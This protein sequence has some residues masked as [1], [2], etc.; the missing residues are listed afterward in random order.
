MAR[1]I[2]NRK[3][4]NKQKTSLRDNPDVQA[5]TLL[6]VGTA[7]WKILSVTS[8]IDF[9]LSIK[10]RYF[11]MTY[12]FLQSTGWWLIILFSIGYAI[13]VYYK[14]PA[15]QTKSPNWYQV[16]AFSVLSFLF[17][18]LV[19][20]RSSSAV[21]DVLASWGHDAMYCSG[22]IDTSRLLSFKDKY[23]VGLVCGIDDPTSERLDDNR[24]TISKPFEIVE[25][26]VVI[27]APYRPV[28]LELM[29]K[30]QSR[31]F[32]LWFE[33]ILIPIN[34]P[35]DKILTLS[36]VQTMGGKILREQYFE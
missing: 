4:P 25:G 16:L 5:S 19:A 18:M 23:K 31:P 9:L 27:H 21:P 34:I 11:A 30:Y 33:V 24:I 35:T 1:K 14:K 13:L 2:G 26:G 12:Q 10:E 36:D 3:T 15:T 7:L 6:V 8:N 29:Q 28:T 20:I 32:F 17:G 22:T